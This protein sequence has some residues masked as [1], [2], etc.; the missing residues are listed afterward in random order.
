M[1]FAIFALSFPDLVA[2][3]CL[4]FGAQLKPRSVVC[5]VS[6]ASEL[7]AWKTE[8]FQRRTDGRAWAGTGI[9]PRWRVE[10]TQGFCPD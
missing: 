8:G 10:H 3:F 9:L 4:I 5:T 7:G 1:S 2:W 6:V